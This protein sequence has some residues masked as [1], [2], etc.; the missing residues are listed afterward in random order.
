MPPPSLLSRRQPTLLRSLSSRRASLLKIPE[1]RSA[2]GLCT[3]TRQ[4]SILVITG[5]CARTML[6]LLRIFDPGGQAE[7]M[8][9]AS[10]F[11]HARCLSPLVAARGLSMQPRSCSIIVATH[12]LTWTMYVALLVLDD[13]SFSPPG[14]VRGLCIRCGVCSILVV[15]VEDDARL[16]ARLILAVDGGCAETVHAFGVFDL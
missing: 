6:A 5:A 14:A 10:R 7:T 11:A 12:G 15:T 4:C 8:H 3:R 9:A 16:W 1:E 13:R 2:Q